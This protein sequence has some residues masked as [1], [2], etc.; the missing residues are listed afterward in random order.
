MRRLVIALSTAAIIG[1]PAAGMTML[2]NAD[3]G[4]SG[5]SNPPGCKNSSPQDHNKNCPKPTT[6]PP[7]PANPCASGGLSGATIA[8][9]AYDG[10]LSG[11]PIFHNPQANGPLSSQLDSGLAPLNPVGHEAACAVSLLDSTP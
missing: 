7:P 8:K 6:P 5:H 10:G 11:V 1:A 4:G 3:T 2:A 9:Q